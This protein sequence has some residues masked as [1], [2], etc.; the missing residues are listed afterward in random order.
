MRILAVDTST[1]WGGLALVEGPDPGIVT[2]ELGLQV[3]QTHASVLL[4]GIE[5]L[6]DL[7]GWSR[8]SLDG[9]VATR[10]PGSFTGIRVGLG[11][12]MGLG[13]ATDR[14]CAGVN[15]LDAIAAAH[16]PTVAERLVLIGAGRGELFGARYDAASSSPRLIAGPWVDS[17]E[18]IVA[19]AAAGPR[20][21]VVPAPG[22][23]AL[24]RDSL[25]REAGIPISASPRSVAAAAG[26]L[27]LANRVLLGEESAES[28]SPLY[29]R[30]P[31]AVLKPAPR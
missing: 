5:H 22:T 26:Q 6:L 24:L 8:S 19:R 18:T 23:E 9:Y 2:A 10:G 25:F 27:A 17:P 15:T 21:I 29:L 20:A 13:L 16:G 7:V 28:L 30:P 4:S 31:D 3:G 12:I 14:P 11:T 1:W